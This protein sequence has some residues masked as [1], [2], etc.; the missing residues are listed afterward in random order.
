M[1]SITPCLGNGV[2][3]VINYAD[4]SV[5]SVVADVDTGQPGSIVNYI[6]RASV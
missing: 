1:T 4:Q 6:C 2:E 5:Q 3:W